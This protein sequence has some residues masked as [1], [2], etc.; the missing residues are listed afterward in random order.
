V[1]N[2]PPPPPPDVAALPDRGEGGKVASV[3]ERL[4]QHRKNP[5]CSTCHAPMDP[6]GFALENFDAIGG[7]R[8]TEAGSAIDASGALP[9]GSKFEGPAGLREVLLRQ[10][11]QFVRTVTEKLTMYALG[12]G[13]EY[14]D[15]PVIRQITRGAAPNDYRW[16]SIIIGIV[17][18]TPFQMRRSQD[19]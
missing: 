15:L 5:V 12:R 9:N 17:K 1:G 2:P 11:G 10:R 14:Y 4:E 19:Q 6:L 7:W 3:R 18:S 16:S 8:S 13:V